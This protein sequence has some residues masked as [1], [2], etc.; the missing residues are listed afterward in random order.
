MK[1]PWAHPNC[2]EYNRLGKL[3]IKKKREVSL[4]CASKEVQDRG[5][6]LLSAFGTTASGKGKRL[7]VMKGQD[8]SNLG[9]KGL[10]SLRALNSS[11]GRAMGAGTQGWQEPGSRS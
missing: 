1:V 2:S 6:R 10:I 5:L 11:P 8:H 9:G 3:H 4:E 7:A